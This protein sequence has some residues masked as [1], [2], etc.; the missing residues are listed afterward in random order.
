MEALRDRRVVILGGTI[1]TIGTS[2]TGLAT[3]R[4]ASPCAADVLIAGRSQASVEAALSS[5]DGRAAGG[6]STSPSTP[7]CGTGSLRTSASITWSRPPRAPEC[8]SAPDRTTTPAVT[9]VGKFWSP[10]RAAAASPPSSTD[11]DEAVARRLHAASFSCSIGVSS[12][13]GVRTVRRT[14]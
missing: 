1:G 9:L 6:R 14:W 2:D 10:Y 13:T 4:H 8:P 12:A 11:R 3:A 7:T 5:V